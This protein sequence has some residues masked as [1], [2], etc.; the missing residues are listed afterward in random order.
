MQANETPGL[1]LGL[2]TS[3]LD[4]GDLLNFVLGLNCGAG[5]S[6]GFGFVAV[7]LSG[8]S[9]NLCTIVL[10]VLLNILAQSLGGTQNNKKTPDDKCTDTNRDYNT[11]CQQYGEKFVQG[12]L[13]TG[14]YNCCLGKEAQFD[15]TCYARNTWGVREYELHSDN[16]IQMLGTLAAENNNERCKKQRDVGCA[17]VTMTGGVALKMHRDVVFISSVLFT[18]ALLCLVLMCW[19]AAS[20]GRDKMATEALDAGYWAAAKQWASSVLLLW[21]SFSL[22]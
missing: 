15:K 2:D 17:F 14:D 12:W 7:L 13:C 22:V 11:I 3:S 10:D 21:Q 5:G 9:T 16:T 1:L 6:T 18:I 19:V 4:V 8:S 20:F